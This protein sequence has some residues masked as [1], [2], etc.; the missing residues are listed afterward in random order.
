MTT[1]TNDSSTSNLLKVFDS[2]SIQ[3][4]NTISETDLKFCEQQQ[5]LLYKTLDRIRHWYD[6]FHEEAGKYVESHSLSYQKDGT[7]TFHEHY[8]KQNN[9]A[10]EYGKFEFK[11]FEV[12]NRLAE[13][14]KNAVHAFAENIIRYF[15]SKYSVSVPIPEIDSNLPLDFRP[16][17]TGY[18]SLVE[19]H[20]QGRGFRETAEEEIVNRFHALVRPYRSSDLPQL[21]SDKIIFQRPLY[22]AE[23]YHA[24]RYRIG[25]GHEKK[26]DTLCEG[27]LFG[28]KTL[29]NGNS[30]II[31]NFNYMEIDIFWWYPLTFETGYAIK[32]YK[33]NRID[34]LFPDAE[35]AKNCFKRLHLN[36]LK[37]LNNE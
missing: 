14:R 15:N 23:T 29:L 34:V 27:I 33:N 1:K 28:S 2:L 11:P 5:M 19:H 4:E 12:I 32:F 21:K 24:S 6:I 30:G 37:S 16:L 18:T 7:L 22:I 9:D 20:L 25:Y 8:R 35:K 26:L 10:P 31:R 3:K 13:Q 36:D 17:Y